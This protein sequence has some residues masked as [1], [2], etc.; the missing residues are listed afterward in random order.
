M[1]EAGGQRAALGR[2]ARA[3]VTRNAAEAAAALRLAGS[4]PVLLLSAPGAAGS[5]GATG[6]RALVEAARRAAPNAMAADALCCG[7]APGHALAALR[8]GCRL[9]VLEAA[10]PAFPAV[11]DAAAACGARVLPARPAALDLYGLDL[12]KPGGRGKLL[13]WLQAVA[14]APDDSGGAKG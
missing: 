5:L 2:D 12:R 4:L 9:L 6:W 10:C 7:D 11:R 13:G 3:V 14:P 1:G 8:A